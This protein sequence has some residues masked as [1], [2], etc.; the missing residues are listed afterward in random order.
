MS[1]AP[2]SFQPVAQPIHLTRHADAL[3]ARNHVQ[4]MTREIH[5]S[6]EDGTANA[7]LPKNLDEACHIFF[8]AHFD[9]EQ[10]KMALKALKII[11]AHK[12]T[13]RTKQTVLAYTMVQLGINLSQ[14]QN[15]IT[16]TVH[17]ISDILHLRHIPSTTVRSNRAAKK[18]ESIDWIR[19]DLPSI[20]DG[21]IVVNVPNLSETQPPICVSVDVTSLDFEAVEYCRLL[22]IP[23]DTR[24][25]SAQQLLME[26]LD[27]EQLDTEQVDPWSEQTTPLNNNSSFTPAAIHFVA[28]GVTKSYICRL[29]RGQRPH[30]RDKRTLKRKLR[31]L[32]SAYGTCLSR[33]TNTIQGDPDAFALYAD[34]R[35]YIMY[36]FR[37]LK[38]HPSLKP[39][40]T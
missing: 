5:C 4:S 38:R 30:V 20:Q 24:M 6:N 23:S 10:C 8:G 35:Y 1:A 18:S 26:C 14:L 16:G 11:G 22:H 7:A 13:L 31:Q 37:F 9:N 19:G 32:K 33:H 15:L 36:A 21:N 25:T 34:G 27:R 39:R 29:D 40:A 12:T 17:G 3:S 2:S 28:R